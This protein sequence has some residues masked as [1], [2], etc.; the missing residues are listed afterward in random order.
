MPVYDEQGTLVACT[1]VDHDT[2]YKNIVFQDTL[3]FL[4]HGVN[5]VEYRFESQQF[6]PLGE[7]GFGDEGAGQRFEQNYG[8]TMHLNHEFTFREGTTLTCTSDDDLWV[9]VNGSL[10]MDLGGLHGAAS[11]TL[12]LLALGLEPGEKCTLSVFYAERGPCGATLRIASGLFMPEQPTV[13]R[14]GRVRGR[15]GLAHPGASCHFNLRG[16]QLGMG[17]LRSGVRITVR[18]HEENPHLPP[19]RGSTRKI[20][21]F[22]CR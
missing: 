4:L 21:G 14:P 7:K 18:A 15:A 5:P 13:A 8:F 6:D 2:L 10:V 20:S 19:A 17:D 1:S 9:F 11:D 16:R 3:R 12:H 22:R